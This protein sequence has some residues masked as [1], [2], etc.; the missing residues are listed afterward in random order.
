[1]KHGARIAALEGAL[2]ALR[3]KVFGVRAPFRGG[4]DWG[5]DHE[6]LYLAMEHARAVLESHD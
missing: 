4:A 6:A 3:L 1:M 2:R 5:A